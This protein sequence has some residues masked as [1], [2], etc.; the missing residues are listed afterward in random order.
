MDDLTRQSRTHRLAGVSTESARR[1]DGRV[2]LITGAG[3]GIGAGIAQRFAAEGARLML[4]DLDGE[5]AR[6]SAATIEARGGRAM[7][8]AADV[9]VRADHERALAECLARFGRVDILVNNAGVSQPEPYLE[10]GDEVWRRI[11]D[12]NLFGV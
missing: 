2:A 3:G 9:R 7:W 1:L 5:T 4:T 10:L 11:F 12:T 8:L 6:T